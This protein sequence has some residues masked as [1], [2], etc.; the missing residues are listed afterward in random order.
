MSVMNRIASDRASLAARGAAI[1]RA[2][3]GHW[4]AAGGM[5]RCPAHEDRS[6]SLSVRVGDTSLLFKCFAGCDVHAVLR[7][8]ARLDLTTAMAGPVDPPI[9]APAHRWLLER[10]TD[11]W[12]E[13]RPIAATPA[14]RYLATRSLAPDAC[15]TDAIR[16]HPRTPLRLANRLQHRPAMLAAVQEG[17]TI[18]ALQR[19]FLDVDAAALAHDLDNPRRMLGRPGRGAV[20]LALPGDTLA[21]AEGLETAFSAMHLLGVPVWATLGTERFAQIAIPP[22]VTRL[23]LLPDNDRAGRVALRRALEVYRTRDGD[24]RARFP[25]TPF[26]DWNDV[27]RSAGVRQPRAEARSK[28]AIYAACAT[29]GTVEE[30]GRGG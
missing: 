24:L 13:A 23:I 25:P 22:H 1:V 18:V 4:S 20:R 12:A 15:R 7:A 30:R 29:D 10:I 21:L 11:L 28:A 9:R 26:K 5:C 27:L 3:G 8:L 17:G 19:S 6:P 2:L 14:F 16:Y